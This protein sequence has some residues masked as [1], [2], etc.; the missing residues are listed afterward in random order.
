MQVSLKPLSKEDLPLLLAWAWISEVWEY[1]PTSRRGERLTWEKHNKWFSERKWR[2]DWKI[3]VDGRAVGSIHI[4]N[5]DLDYPEIGLYIAEIPL[6][7]EGV[8]RRAIELVLKLY[9]TMK[10]PGL[11]AVIHPNNKRSI[12]LFTGLGFMKIGGARNGQDL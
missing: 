8:G 5:M 2:S 11:H 4:S 3:I 12:R 7:G 10:K 6:W 1:M 9:I